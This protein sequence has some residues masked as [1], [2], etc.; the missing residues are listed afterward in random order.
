MAWLYESTSKY[1]SHDVLF[2]NN[3]RLSLKEKYLLKTNK[4]IITEYKCLPCSVKLNNG[5]NSLPL[6][7]RVFGS[8]N[9]LKKECAQACK[10]LIR[11][12]GVYSNS[13]ATNSIASGGVRARNT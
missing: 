11:E 13:R 10:G 7:K 6:G 8:L 12:D 2:G 5:G 9:S 1:W 3:F 4:Y